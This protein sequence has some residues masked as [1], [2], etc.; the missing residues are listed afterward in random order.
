MEI[1]NERKK[2]INFR[3]VVTIAAIFLTGILSAFLS[4]ITVIGGKI[5]FSAVAVAIVLTVIFTFKRN[6]TLAVTLITAFPL[7]IYGFSAPFIKISANVSEKTSGV[8]EI[9]GEVVRSDKVLKGVNG[10]ENTVVVSISGGEL[11]G[12]KLLVELYCDSRADKGATVKFS[13]YVRPLRYYDNGYLS[14]KNMKNGVTLKGNHAECEITGYKTG[15]FDKTRI[16]L[17]E[18]LERGAGENYGFTYALLTGDTNDINESV[19]TAFRTNGLAHVFA[20]SGL[21]IGFLF[22]IIAAVCKIFKVK[23]FVKFFITVPVLFLYV[24]FCGFT[25][26]CMRAFLIITVA[27]AAACTGM[28]NDKLSTLFLSMIIVLVLNPEDLFGVG[29]ILSYS[30]YFG[31]VFL[32]PVINKFLSRFILGGAAKF[33][34]PLVAAYLSSLPVCADMFGTTSVFSMFLNAIVISAVGVVFTVAFVCAV[35]TLITGANFPCAVSGITS[36]ALIKFVK[37]FEYLGGLK[38]DFTFGISAF[39]YYG[40]LI[41]SCKF[42]NFSEKTDKIVSAGIFFAFILTFTF[43]NCGLL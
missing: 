41:F 9:S 7:F 27:E 28:K 38:I 2:Y 29:F 17:R 18:R 32:T 30:V 5:V 34:S 21:H 11:D 36:G 37:S 12:K 19:L 42:V 15:V 22:G 24:A 33:L 25:A 4:L 23:R 1:E 16:L 6:K 8:Y 26:S 10:F 3:P 39:L 40:L 43:V 31:I 20:V 35:I 13:T 14:V